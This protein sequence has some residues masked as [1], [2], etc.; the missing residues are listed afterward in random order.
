MRGNSRAGA[1]AVPHHKPEAV[2]RPRSLMANRVHAMDTTK[3]APARKPQGVN[4]CERHAVMLH[5]TPLTMKRI[6]H[7]EYCSSLPVTR[8]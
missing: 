1:P 8:F 7:G 2:E 3:K 5:C 4:T 6:M